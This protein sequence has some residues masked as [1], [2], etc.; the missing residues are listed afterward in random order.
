MTKPGRVAR[1]LVSLQL[2]SPPEGVPVK[3]DSSVIEVDTEWA[4]S[5]LLIA[6]PFG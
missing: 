1:R 2:S 6:H 5:L 4:I 3:G